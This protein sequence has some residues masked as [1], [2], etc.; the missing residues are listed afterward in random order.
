MR[1][2]VLDYTVPLLVSALCAQVA[3]IVLNVY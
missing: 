1:T 2:L 3:A